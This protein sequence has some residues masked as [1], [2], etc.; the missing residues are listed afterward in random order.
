[1]IF[2]VF[3]RPDTTGVVFDRI[4][5]MKPKRLLVIADGPRPER[6]GEAARCQQVRQ[7][8]TAVTWDC[9]LLTNFSDVNLGSRR[10]VVS[11]L[12]WAFQL[13][14]E[15]IILED[16]VLPDPSFFP[17][18]AEMLERFR[19]DE[20]VATIG[21]FNVAADGIQLPYSYCFSELTPLW[22]WATWRNRWA[23]YDEHMSTWPEVV[24]SGMVSDLFYEKTVLRYWQP[25]F[26]AMYDGTAT[27]D[28][29]DYQ[30][31]YMQ[32]T[33]RALCV[34]PSLNLITNIG[35][36]AFATHTKN[37]SSAPS[38]SLG[39]I[40]FPL[41]HPPAMIPSHARDAL[42]LKIRGFIRYGAP[43]RA[44]RKLYRIMT[45]WL[46]GARKRDGTTAGH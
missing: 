32:L 37:Q 30:W 15:A 43:K 3:S 16:D 20:K 1:M 41:R 7:I 9:E 31:T 34:L 13:V 45:S 10:R 8:A 28:A 46:R 23:K 2:I 36:G 4:A 39:S 18:C 29:W 12:D 22:G 17:F 6:E 40:S 38:V 33:S 25:I 21:G 24:S 44:V 27:V 42:D 5:Q 14:E 11:G 35:F 19:G 26:Q